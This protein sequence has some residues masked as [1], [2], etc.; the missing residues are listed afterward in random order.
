MKTVI[1]FVGG[2]MNQDLDERLV[3]PGQ[4]VTATN[5]RT[6][7]SE[8]TE[9][10]SVEKAQGNK[11][12]QTI[13]YDPANESRISNNARCIGAYRDDARDRVFWFIHD[14]DAVYV[15]N[16]CDLIVSYQPSTGVLFYHIID[17]N[18]VLNFSYDYLICSV[19]L[20]E[21]LLFWTDGYNPP[22]RI[23][24]RQ[25]VGN[26]T[27]EAINVIVSPPTSA[28]EVTLFES[29]DVTSTNF[30]IEN[31]V[32]FAY[33]YR[34]ENGEYS[35]LSQFSDI[36][37]SPQ[38][39]FVDPNTST[40][41][42]MVNRYNA[43]RI[44]YN[45]G[46]IL[47][48]DIELCYKFA[49]SNE[50][51]VIQRLNKFKNNIPSDS[52][53]N[54][55]FT[56]N[57][58]YSTLPSTEWFRLYDNVPHKAV[59]QTIMGNRL[60]YGN[61]FEGHDLIDNEGKSLRLGYSVEPLSAEVSDVP[62]T[63]SL[64]SHSYPSNWGRTGSPAQPNVPNTKFRIDIPT[65]FQTNIPAGFTISFSIQLQGIL[66]TGG[67][68]AQP[69]FRL[70]FSFTTQKSYSNFFRLKSSNEFQDK[71][72]NTPAR[73][74]SVPFTNHCSA[75][76]S[77]TDDFACAISDKGSFVKT[78]L[79]SSSI[80]NTG[81]QEQQP[82]N[83]SVLDIIVPAMVF[84]NG[85][86]YT[87]EWYNILSMSATASRSG[88][89]KSLH[90]N[91]DYQVGIVYMD[92]Y[93]R[94]TTALTSETNTVF[95]PA[96][97]S[98][99]QN[100]IKVTIPSAQKP[101]VWA[102]R[103][104]FVIKP[105]KEK[106]ETIFS[107]RF[108]NE[109]LDG[110]VWV[111]LDGESQSK[112]NVG[113]RLIVKAD[114]GGPLGNYVT[115]TVL[116]K[117]AK[118]EDWITATGDPEVAGVYMRL[119]KD[120]WTAE[121][122]PGS[123]IDT[124]KLTAEGSEDYTF[125]KIP[126]H[127]SAGV[128]WSIN[129]GDIVYINFWVYRFG[130][131][132]TNFLGV[133]PA[134][135]CG[136]VDSLY[137]NKV[138]A[139]RNYA[140]F[141]DFWNREGIN[142]ADAAHPTPNC[143]DDAGQNSDVYE[144]LI[145]AGTPNARPGVNVYQFS[146]ESGELKLNIRSGSLKCAW[147]NPKV[148]RIEAQITIQKSS[149][150]SLVF[151]TEPTDAIPDLYYENHESFAIQGGF[152]LCNQ[153]NQTSSVAGVSILNFFNC[154]SFGNGVESYK[155]K[156]S[157]S[158]NYFLLGQRV[159]SVSETEYKR[160]HRFSDITYSG[161]YNRESN[162][163][164]L[165]EFNPGLFNFKELEI[166]YGSIQ[167][168]HQRQ[169]DILV[170]QEDRVSRVLVGKNILSDT[171]GG[172][173]V[174]SVPE[175]LGN[176]V[177]RIEEFGISTK[178]ESFATYGNDV[179][180][181][182]IQRGAVLRLSGEQ[183]FVLSDIGMR[184]FFRDNFRQIKNAHVFGGFDPFMKDYVVHVESEAASST[185]TVSCG[186]SRS[187]SGLKTLTDIIVT[188]PPT[189]GFVD[190]NVFGPFEGDGDINVYYDNNLE[191][192]ISPITSGGTITFTKTSTVVNSF[193]IQVTPTAQPLSFSFSTTCP[194]SN[195][196]NVYAVVLASAQDVEIVGQIGFGGTANESL[197]AVEVFG[198]GDGYPRIAYEQVYENVPIGS[199]FLP[200]DNEDFNMY[201]IDTQG[202]FSTNTALDRFRFLRTSTTYNYT[203]ATGLN[204]LIAAA[205]TSTPALSSDYEP[206]TAYKSTF[207]MAN[208]GDKIYMIWDYRR[209]VALD[210]CYS[211]TNTNLALVCC[212]CNIPCPTIVEVQTTGVFSTQT[213]ACGA[214]I[215]M[216]MYYE[217]GG[218]AIGKKFYYDDDMAISA[219]PGF[220]HYIDA[221]NKYFEVDNSGKVI[222]TGTC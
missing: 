76:T 29:G 206:Y 110:T 51:R 93:N 175:V 135:D 149:T 148:P 99:Y 220:Y 212:G 146:I 54:F 156:D 66:Y 42:G 221:G 21:D 167:K 100:K 46:S 79:G 9:V 33:R 157:I 19:N 28:P 158:K 147:P 132:C 6:G 213:L 15:N 10:G 205:T 89:P 198:P 183:L 104:K 145:L 140:D 172:G 83:D 115:T 50:I 154:F 2:K 41:E 37:F 97:T 20:I 171:T 18:N 13:F 181:T 161:V 137:V 72:G 108:Y 208:S 155:I 184:N 55:N 121:Y 84:F 195:E 186:S 107:S 125:I 39:F 92:E 3:P 200:L 127:D 176:Q 111:K 179:F 49:D 153:T 177:A 59:A 57:K 105:T 30:L 52:T 96:S 77:L 116:D 150:N 47:V 75:G 196:L 4:Y 173:P 129:A 117:E 27:A 86:T 80:S 11:L 73:Y 199:L 201:S 144:S 139:T 8:S 188:L 189:L 131:G 94:S 194:Y 143:L 34:Y 185:I 7:S 45:T 1:N 56:N 142:V 5:V 24:V 210:M 165:N 31:F 190:L 16:T 163:N 40:N 90:S 182:D 151:E 71:L 214:R 35:A 48:K 130:R 63:F 67:T 91:R 166:S 124:G 85:A 133:N 162:V 128:N 70:E 12:I 82:F 202:Q 98:S 64:L 209:I 23:N 152:H 62:L 191:A 159:T 207:N 25:S 102:S 114:T 215:V 81:F 122:Q 36:A 32:S 38:D 197:N 44:T 95:F 204:S 134:P 203:T 113:A 160:T 217:G 68:P 17:F 192:T 120:G 74:Q 60:M 169:T 109:P 69:A 180:F 26:L 174:V 218:I 126:C 211:S 103:Y 222:K 178:P 53:A 14:E 138:V 118:P 170:L 101:P 216:T 87:Y 65:E 119:Q 58:I 106:Y 22:R 164:K 112:V 193:I 141:R 88:S 61:Y 136:R 123:Y 187:I 168:M 219:Y 78:S 43:A